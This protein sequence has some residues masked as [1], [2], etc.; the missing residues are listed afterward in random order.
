MGA[1]Q[2]RAKS[3]SGQIVAGQ[4]QASSKDE[5]L[6]KVRSHDLIPMEIISLDKESNKLVKGVSL[7]ELQVFTRQ[8]ASCVGSG[9]PILQS[10]EA[11]LASGRSKNL[12]S[13]LEDIIAQIGSGKK[14]A[15]SLRRHPRAFDDMYVNLVA[16]GE[17]SGTLEGTLR[18]LAVYIERSVALRRQAIGAMWYPAMVL[19]VTVV[20][21]AVF[22]VFI[23]PSF[24][25]MFS[26]AGADLPF[27]TQIVVNMSEFVRAK[28]YM[29]IGF[30]VAAGFAAKIAYEQKQVRDGIDYL[31][32]KIP[33]VEGFV[34]YSSA[35]QFMLTLATLLKAGAP[36]LKSLD[37]ATNAVN[38][39]V[40]SQDL[41]V[42]QVG[43][44]KGLPLGT[45]LG[46]AK[47]LPPMA[48]QMISIGEQ[49]GDLDSML[50]KAGLFFKEEVDVKVN[51][52]MTLIEPL[53]MVFIGCIVGTLVLSLYWPIFELAGTIK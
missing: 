44:E 2:Y 9:I 20:I 43:V 33:V 22:M 50:D 14:L 35:A 37:L 18:Q 49:S 12:T 4:V 24:Q 52:M 46:S 39:S 31:L 8:F 45:S 10:L 26:A 38:N 34:I 32:L 15:E 19:V 36:I 17:E 1:F 30:I 48:I 6:S 47:Y 3:V 53:L 7:K 42:A 11:L 28:W 13:I 41:S 21:I 40:I 25:K 16:V 27:L 23:I 29:L 5:A 51:A